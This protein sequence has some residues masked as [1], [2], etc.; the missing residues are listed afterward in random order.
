MRSP[1]KRELVGRTI[2]D[3]DLRPWS[4]KAG[5]YTDPLITLDDG[6]RLHFT[7]QETESGEYGVAIR[8]FKRKATK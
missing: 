5:R 2:V 8:R 6:S 1:N 4:D 7:T 3:F